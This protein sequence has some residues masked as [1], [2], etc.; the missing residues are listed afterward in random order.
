MPVP[1]S[2]TVSGLDGALLAVVRLP[3]ADPA[4]VGANVTLT[5]HDPLAA[6]EAPQVLVCVNGPEAASCETETAVLLGLVTVTVCAPLLDPTVWLPNDRLDGEAFS[7]LVGPPP[8][9]L[10]KAR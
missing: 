2:A 1:D 7:A 5:V 3:L 9:P 4:A 10:A 6:I 8:L